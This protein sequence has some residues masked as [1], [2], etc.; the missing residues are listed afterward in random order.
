MRCELFS[1]VKLILVDKYLDEN[2]GNFNYQHFSQ[3]EQEAQL[4]QK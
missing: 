3:I 4:S 2:R 1:C